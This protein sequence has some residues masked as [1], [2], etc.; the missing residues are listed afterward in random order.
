MAVDSITSPS[1]SGNRRI[2]D[3][4]SQGGATGRIP[5]R[6]Y[7]DQLIQ[8]ELDAA[9]NNASRNRMQTEQIRQFDIGQQNAMETADA[10]R[11][12]SQT[13]AMTNLA[14]TAGALYLMSPKSA[15]GAL[16]YNAGVTQAALNPIGAK[17]LPV[18]STPAP[19]MPSGGFIPGTATS[20][21]SVVTSVPSAVGTP[22]SASAVAGETAPALMGE[23]APAVNVAGDTTLLSAAPAAGVNTAGVTT[24]TGATTGAPALMGEAAP[25]AVAGGEAGSTASFAAPYAWPALAGFLAPGLV[26]SLGDKVFGQSESVRQLGKNLSFGMAGQKESNMIG[27]TVTGAAAGAA[28]GL[29]GGPLAPITVPIGAIIG[30]VTGFISSFF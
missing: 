6:R 21:S 2:M 27:S 12:A 14:T 18:Y 19:A 20:Q 1:L 9:E 7:L 11:K 8:S 29:I 5:S 28:V 24:A 17:G 4:F 30:G 23:A 25:A 16:G 26:N 22:A 15:T 13:S 10:N 3:A